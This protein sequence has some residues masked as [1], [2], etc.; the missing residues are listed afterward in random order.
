MVPVAPFA[1]LAA[2]HHPH[3]QPAPL[4]NGAVGGDVLFAQ[5]QQSCDETRQAPSIHPPAFPR[6]GRALSHLGHDAAE[7]WWV[8]RQVGRRCAGGHH[9]HARSLRKHGGPRRHRPAGYQTPAGHR[10]PY[11]S[12]EGQHRQPLRLHRKRPPRPAGSRRFEDPRDPP[13][14]RGHRHRRRHPRDVP[15]GAGVSR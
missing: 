6:A 9:R 5:G 7:D 1:V 15:H 13:N 11:G 12:G 3:A 8:S 2:D 4:Q 10:A 14:R